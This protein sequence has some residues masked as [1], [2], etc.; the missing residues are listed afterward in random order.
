MSRI[1]K[2]CLPRDGAKAALRK[3]RIS[4]APVKLS[5][6]FDIVKSVLQ[7]FLGHDQTAPQRAHRLCSTSLKNLE[8]RLAMLW[9]AHRSG[10][11]ITQPAR[12]PL[13][14]RSGLSDKRADVG[15]PRRH[16]Q[17][18]SKTSRCGT[19]GSFFLKIGRDGSRPPQY[20]HVICAVGLHPI[21]PLVGKSWRSVA[22]PELLL[23][24]LHGRP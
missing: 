22:A 5:S 21:G 6:L 10:D 17:D 23:G 2:G 19:L 14:D 16:R 4:L 13:P 15:K 11:R 24:F 18:C 7:T 8:W 3:Q 1:Q 12:H 9:L 20:G